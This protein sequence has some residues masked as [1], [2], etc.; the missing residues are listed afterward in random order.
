MQLAVPLRADPTA[1]LAGANPLARLGAGAAVMVAGLAAGDLLTPALLLL[2]VVAAV[3]L[4]GMGTWAL[5]RRAWPLLAAALAAGAINALLPADRTGS[6]LLEIGPM[7]PTPASL[8]TGA[9]LA[10]RVL[11]VA[12]AGVVAVAP[13]DPTDLADALM[14]HLRVSPRFALGALAALR[15]VP[16][17]AADWQTIRLARRARGVEAGRNPLAAARLFAGGLLALLV[18]A[19]RRAT[20]LALAMESRGLG[21]RPCR[22][23]ARPQPMPRRDWALL[24]AGIAVA[25]GATAISVAAGSWRPLFG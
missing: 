11:A 23:Q 14:E 2:A 20:R 24:G 5:V 17:L 3:P 12:L 15:L 4:S 9:A 6:A 8:A 1:T 25:V 21:S 18:A 7:R 19:I 22:T 16:L 10:V 13:I